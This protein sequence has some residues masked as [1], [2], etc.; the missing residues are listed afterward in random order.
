MR[1]YRRQGLG[2]YVAVSI[3]DRYRGEWVVSQIYSNDVSRTFWEK[4]ISDY[5]GGHYEKREPSKTGL[6]GSSSIL[7]ILRYTEN[8]VLPNPA[9]T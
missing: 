3:F 7:T 2:K 8:N 4:I 1:K 5:T 9:S 6:I